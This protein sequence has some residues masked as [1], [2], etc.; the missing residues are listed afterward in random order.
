MKGM[1]NLNKLMKQAQAMQGKMAEVQAELAEREV[2][3]QAGGG[4]VTVTMTGKMEITK[5]TVKPEVVDPDDVEMLEDT[6]LAAI[7]EAHRKASEMV[8][9]EM[10]KVTGGMGGMPGLF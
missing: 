8:E 3:G 9:T 10:A 4:A 6:L 7:R 5:V 2:E 1:G